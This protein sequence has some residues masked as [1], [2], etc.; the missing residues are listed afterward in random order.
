MY[1]FLTYCNS[2]GTWH[3]TLDQLSLFYVMT[4]SITAFVK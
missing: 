1:P 2:L 4:T 3:S